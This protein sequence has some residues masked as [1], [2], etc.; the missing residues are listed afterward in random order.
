MEETINITQVEFAE[1]WVG[2]I[3]QS[4]ETLGPKVLA[5]DRIGLCL[6]PHCLANVN[7]TN[8]NVT[9]RKARQYSRGHIACIT[10]G[11]EQ[12]TIVDSEGVEI[13]AAIVVRSQLYPRKPLIYGE[14]QLD[15]HG[16]IQQPS[17][18]SQHI[19]VRTS[20]SRRRKGRVRGEILQS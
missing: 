20:L 4:V 2:Y 8:S 17:R 1:E 11:G 3:L 9:I 15:S 14:G 6:I 10:P 7:G 12:V 13:E 18:I 5:S 19:C 16:R